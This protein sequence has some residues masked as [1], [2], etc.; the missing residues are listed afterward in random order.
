MAGSSAEERS[1]EVLRLLQNY[2]QRLN[3]RMKNAGI[4]EI[5]PLASWVDGELLYLVYRDSKEQMIQGLVR[6]TRASESII[7]GPV[8]DPKKFA[9]E[10]G[11]YDIY[12]PRGAA[13]YT[14]RGEI[15]WRGNHKDERAH[16]PVDL[17][18]AL[19]HG[20]VE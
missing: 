11:A 2:L 1:S 4:G 9:F 12:E 5:V 7:V 10:L 19:A 14:I 6:D 16:L 17:G 15:M 20:I 13:G 18:D 3:K 8:E